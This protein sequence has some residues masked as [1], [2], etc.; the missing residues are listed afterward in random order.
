MR[1]NFLTP[2][3]K[4]EPGMPGRLRIVHPDFDFV[5]PGEEPQ[6]QRIMPVYIRP[7]GL[8]VSLMRRWIAQILSEYCAYLPNPLPKEVADRHG[9][10]A[11]P[12][13]LAQLHAPPLD[14]DVDAFNRFSSPAHRTII[15][16]EL[17]YLQLGLGQRKR[18]RSRSPCSWRA[19]L[20]AAAS[21]HRSSTR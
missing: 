19:T 12:A 4:V 10:M 11:V 13:A 2:G 14:I 8:S 20:A 15:F 9:L 6:L 17:F 7:T 16:E 5:E 3:E 18:S 21:G 1:G